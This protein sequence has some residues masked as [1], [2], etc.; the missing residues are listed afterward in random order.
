[1]R[2]AWRRRNAT[3]LHTRTDNERTEGGLDVD[4]VSSIGYET[5][6]EDGDG[7]GD[8]ITSGIWTCKTTNNRE[9]ASRSMS[10]RRH[11]PAERKPGEHNGILEWRLH[12]VTQLGTRDLNTSERPLLIIPA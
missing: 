6:D 12:E 5:V 7:D 11:G 2:Q 9:V 3:Y 1:M 8:G 10:R 4:N